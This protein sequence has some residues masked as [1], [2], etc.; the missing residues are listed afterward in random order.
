MSLVFVGLK[1]AMIWQTA[2]DWPIFLA[3]VDLDVMAVC[4]L[5]KWW[6]TRH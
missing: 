4:E 6:V 2:Y 5:R 3:L 1:A